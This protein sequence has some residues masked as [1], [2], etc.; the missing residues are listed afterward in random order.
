M[1][2]YRS[3]HERSITDPEGYWA[4]QA[5]LVD[6]VRRPTRVL[7]AER[8]PFYR[9]YPDGTLN[10]CYNALDRHVVAGHA[11]R[12]AL[13][14]DSPVT[15]TVRRYSYAQLLEQVAAFAGVLRGFGV[16]KGDRV[17]VYMPMI[18]EAV[19]AMLACARL[20]AVHSVVFGGFAP[21]EL[22]IRIDDAR[23]KAVVSASCGIEPSRVVEYKPMLDR[24]LDLA[25][26]KPDVCVVKQRPQAQATM[27]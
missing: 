20:G 25:E 21:H 3:E 13:I 11:D 10:T 26:H 17:V 16:E 8:P 4:E 23:P 22:A 27:V 12:T 5:R 14:Y 1:A 18:P 19:I 7:D 2:D 9:W 15:D 6:W 24:A